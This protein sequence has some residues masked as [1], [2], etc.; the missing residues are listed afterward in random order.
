VFAWNGATVR[1]VAVLLFAAACGLQLAGAAAAIAGSLA[2]FLAGLPHGAFTSGGELLIGR[3]GYALRYAA[4][5][6][7]AALTFL[8]MPVSTLAMFLALSAWHFLRER[9]AGTWLRRAG[10]AGL[11]IGGSAL[12]RTGE[13]QAIFAQLCGTAVPSGLMLGLG[14]AGAVGYAAALAV[15][16]R[17]RT[18]FPLWVMAAAP[19]LFHPVLATGLVFM[20]GHAGP[21]TARLLR[22]RGSPRRAVIATIALSALLAGGAVLALP[23]VSPALLPYLAAGALAIILPHL[24]PHRLLMPDG[25]QLRSTPGQRSQAATSP[26]T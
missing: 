26:A 14:I 8:L 20:L 15:I 17:K 10:I 11:A 21:V 3:R 23:V 1:G 4:L 7:A 22:Q 25:H 13:T 16:A 6:A 5:G 18:D 19:L 2:L 12:I 24:L 9:E